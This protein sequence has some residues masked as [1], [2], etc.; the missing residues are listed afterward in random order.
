[1]DEQWRD[2]AAC[3]NHP[4][5]DADAWFQIINGAPKGQGAEA[6]MV[7]QRAC[8]VMQTCREQYQGIDAIAGGGWFGAHGE[9]Y[10]SN[11]ELLDVYQTAAYLGI[12]VAKVRRLMGK[13]LPVASFHKG[14]NWFQLEDVLRVGKW[15]EPVHGSAQ[16]H[17]LHI[18][19][20]EEPCRRCQ[21]VH[22]STSLSVFANSAEAS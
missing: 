16:A 17:R 9:F 8:P 13:I 5:L 20:G 10:E 22:L 2:Q 4:E 15:Y 7:C 14:R 18:L 12:D 3:H 1:M 6:L 19:R 11:D 21:A